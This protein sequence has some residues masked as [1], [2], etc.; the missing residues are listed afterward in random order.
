MT[1]EQFYKLDEAEQ[2]ETVWKGKHIADR[3]DEEH[4][5]LL[6]QIDDLYVEAYYHIGYN[7]LRKFNSFSRKELLEIYTYHIKN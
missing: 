1:P 4:N 6:Y 5:I 7:V 2:A 3:K